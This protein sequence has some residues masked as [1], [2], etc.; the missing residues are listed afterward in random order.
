M[1][2]EKKIEEILKPTIL[3]TRAE[4]IKALI[5]EAAKSCVGEKVYESCPAHGRFDK[6]C[7]YCSYLEGYNKRHQVALKRI[8][9][10]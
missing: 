9:E 8:E 7:I 2:L 3:K 6:K 10:L 5:K 1:N 4:R